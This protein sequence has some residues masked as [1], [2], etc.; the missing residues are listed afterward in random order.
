MDKASGSW[1]F[2]VCLVLLGSAAGGAGAV[3]CNNKI[4]RFSVFLSR[5]NPDKNPQSRIS[6][7]LFH[8]EKAGRPRRPPAHRH[9]NR[10]TTGST[11]LSPVVSLVE[12][13]RTAG[14]HVRR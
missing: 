6:V 2:K 9:R 11:R 13:L 12:E 7:G 5:V 4:F 8:V 1:R 14:D 10:K 3:G